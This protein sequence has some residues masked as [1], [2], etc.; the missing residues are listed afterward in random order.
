MVMALCTVTAF[1]QKPAAIKTIEKP[2]ASIALADSAVM[3]MAKAV[4]AAHGGDKLRAAKT[5]V[6]RGSVDIT[7][8]AFN[9]AIPSGF[10]MV[11][12]GEKY[13]VELANQIQSFKQ[14][15][16]GEQTFTS[17]QTGFTLPPINRLG[18]PLLARLGDKGFMVSRLPES[19]K[20][21]QGFR[22]TAPDGFYTDFYIDEKTKM[23][24]GYESLYEFSG[25]TAT[26]SVEI[27]KYRTVDGVV[28][29]ER[30]AQRFDLGQLTIYGDFKSK[31]ILV[32][33]EVADDVFSMGK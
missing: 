31:E 22:L 13:R 20:K 5:L 26:T 6:V 9:Q 8:T 12:S 16:D 15:F 4:F 17:V 33:S 28:V 24:K 7:S 30:Y 3:E 27:D 32:N 1:A 10:S 11:I 2:E 21:R 18:L 23:V 25:R 14:V 19:A 29:P